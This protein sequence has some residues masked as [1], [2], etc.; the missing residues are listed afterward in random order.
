MVEDSGKY[1]YSSAPEPE[2]PE[3][4]TVLSMLHTSTYLTIATA[5]EAQRHGDIYLPQVASM[6]NSVIEIHLCSLTPS[7]RYAL[8]DIQ[9]CLFEEL[10]SSGVPLVE[11]C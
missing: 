9:H 1:F 3:G 10:K 6:G 7:R 2:V 8:T 5:G 4:V 11:S